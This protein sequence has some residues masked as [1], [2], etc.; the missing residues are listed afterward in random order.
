MGKFGTYTVKCPK[1]DPVLNFD[2]PYLK[3]DTYDR[4]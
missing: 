3:N 4:F 2:L 1:F